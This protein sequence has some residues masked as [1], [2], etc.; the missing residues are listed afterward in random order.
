MLCRDFGIGLKARTYIQ[1]K[2]KKITNLT[3]NY[4]D[5][6]KKTSFLWEYNA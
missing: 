2:D 6:I 4:S 5:S 1:P 3:K